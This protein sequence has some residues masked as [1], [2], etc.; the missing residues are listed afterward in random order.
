M[1]QGF[2]AL[3]FSG[4]RALGFYGFRVLGTRH[5]QEASPKAES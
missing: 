4:F 2:R 5:K 1:I 3:D